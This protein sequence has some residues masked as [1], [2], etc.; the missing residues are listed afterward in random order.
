MRDCEAEKGRPFNKKED[1]QDA[2]RLI[3]VKEALEEGADEEV[4]YG[5]E[6]RKE[7]CHCAGLSPSAFFRVEEIP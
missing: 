5:K 7:A 4:G 6:C 3:I 2:A 1:G